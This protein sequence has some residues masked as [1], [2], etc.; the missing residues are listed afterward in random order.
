MII[1][2]YFLAATVP[3]V[4]A[5]SSFPIL[6]QPQEV[7]GTVEIKTSK[8]KAKPQPIK[9]AEQLQVTM[10]RF[11]QSKL[12]CAPPVSNLGFENNLVR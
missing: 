5:E 4:L 1:K 11:K 2:C 3:Q 10:Q 12:Q 6:N 8:K 9:T 7:E